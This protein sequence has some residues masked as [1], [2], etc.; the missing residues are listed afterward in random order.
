MAHEDPVFLNQVAV[1]MM[2]ATEIM[3]AGIGHEER[4]GLG[5]FPATGRTISRMIYGT[6]YYFSFGIAFPTLLVVGWLPKNNPVYH[7][8]VDGGRAAND[9]VLQR[10]ERHAIRQ[11]ADRRRFGNTPLRYL[12]KGAVAH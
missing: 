7:G 5:L 4:D 9:A 10:S 11:I 3:E 2:R 12:A 6:C 8:L 1:A